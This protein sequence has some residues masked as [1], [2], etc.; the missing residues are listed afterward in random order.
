[1]VPRSRQAVGPAMLVV[2]LGVC[3]AAA[4]TLIISALLWG[5]GGRLR[6][7]QQGHRAALAGAFRKLRALWI[8]FAVSYSFT[9]LV[10]LLGIVARIAG[11][12]GPAKLGGE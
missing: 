8:W 7:F 11:I 1:M 2:G 9:L 4:L 10:T 6:A 3:L 5:Y 12:G